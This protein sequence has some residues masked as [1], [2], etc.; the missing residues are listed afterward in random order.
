M[1]SFSPAARAQLKELL[2]GEI[3]IAEQLLAE[4]R[5]KIQ[6]GLEKPGEQFRF[7]RDVLG[8]KRQLLAVDG[9]AAADARKQ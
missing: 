3:R 7:E 2:Q 8:L 4:H 9:L 1:Q 6:I 5:K